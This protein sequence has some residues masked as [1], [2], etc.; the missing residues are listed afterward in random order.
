MIERYF[1]INVSGFFVLICSV[2]FVSCERNNL[3]K[4]LIDCDRHFTYRETIAPLFTQHCAN[5][6][7]HDGSGTIGDF[8]RYEEIKTRVDNGK[9]KLFVYD[10]KIMPPD[11]T[12]SQEESKKIECWI[13]QGADN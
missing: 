9:L 5:P 4:E 13:E 1:D 7:C 11:K 8:S 10:L 3:E 12:L 2:L 6:G